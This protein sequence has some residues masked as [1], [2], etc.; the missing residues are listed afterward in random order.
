M[1][2]PPAQRLVLLHGDYRLPNLKWQDG[3]I[4]G[5]LDWELARVGDPLSDLAFTQTIG[6]GPCSIEGDLA[7]RYSELTGIE[8]DERRLLYYRLL[9]LVKGSIIGMAGA[10]DLAN[11]GDDLR[12]ISVAMIAASGQAM[13]GSLEAQLEKFLEA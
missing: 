13:M 7:Q 9:E 5:V 12:L 6:R 4:S 11:G 10:Y 2:A 3:E 8:I 1:Q